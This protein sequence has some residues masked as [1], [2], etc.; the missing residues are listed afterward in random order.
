MLR[1]KRKTGQDGL[2]HRRGKG[3]GREAGSF[4][5]SRVKLL[6]EHLFRLEEETH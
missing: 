2:G 6:P 1:L 5:R 4:V 3:L